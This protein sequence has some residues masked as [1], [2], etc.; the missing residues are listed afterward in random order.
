MSTDQQYLYERCCAIRDGEFSD[1]LAKKY[2]GKMSHARWLTMA[3]RVLRYYVATISPSENLNILT[4]YILKVYAP[5]W[6]QIQSKPLL[7]DGTVHFW[8]AIKASRE[9]PDK[10]KQTVDKVF[11]GNA[12]FAHPENLLVAMLVDSRKNI[13]ELAV[14]RI[15]NARKRVT[16][17]VRAFRV[18]SIN[19][20][21]E[22]YLELI[23]WQSCDVTEPPMTMKYSD[24]DLKDII[25]GRIIP[26][27]DEFPCHTQAVERS[28]KLVTEVCG[29]ISRDGYIRAK[30]QARE[31]LPVFD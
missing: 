27:F 23:H 10:V 5:T 3:N 16:K 4:R 12:Y 28:V 26:E 21:A 22:D 30:L 14:R 13:R 8:K 19:F 29:E 20:N 24:S 18:P 11:A 17:E 6:F 7:I 25:D 9:F 15:Q 1:R 2:P 31:G